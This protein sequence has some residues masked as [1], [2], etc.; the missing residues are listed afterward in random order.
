MRSLRLLRGLV[1]KLAKGYVIAHVK[2]WT[3]SIR[4]KTMEA[5]KIVLII[6]ALN[7]AESIGLVLDAL[8]REERLGIV[9]VDGGSK[10]DTVR[11]ARERGALVLQGKTRGYGDAC[12]AGIQY[13]ASFR[14][15][16]VVFLDADFSDYPEE[17]AR[18]T[19]PILKGEADF[20]LGSRLLGQREEGAMP[21]HAVWG[22]KLACFL[23]K[24][25]YGY[26]FTDLCPF[27]AI[28]FEKLMDLQMRDQDYGWT[29]EMQI[30]A[31]KAGLKILEIP[32]NYRK[33]VGVS[34]I[35]GSFWGS[36]KAGLKIIFT[37]FRFF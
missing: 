36:V 5:K 6:P 13:A 20:V 17:M 14:P 12:L 32:V 2:A 9:V 24:L 34:K 28:R 30:K 29:V 31:V 15:D 7:E 26:R 16:V 10:D 3:F 35:S 23:M 22:N 21:I 25:L 8:P 11:I 18:L 1:K 4:A 33:R 27:R 37:I 19:D